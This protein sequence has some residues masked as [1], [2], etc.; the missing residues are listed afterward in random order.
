MEDSSWIQDAVNDLGVLI[1]HWRIIWDPG[2]TNVC[3]FIPHLWW[4]SHTLV[5][6]FSS[7]FFSANFM[8]SSSESIAPGQHLYHR[9]KLKIWEVRRKVHDQKW[10]VQRLDR[11]GLSTC[12]GG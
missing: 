5:T 9:L 10:F 6:W 4:D 11:E 12:K 7:C 2:T 3:Y 1:R 8:E